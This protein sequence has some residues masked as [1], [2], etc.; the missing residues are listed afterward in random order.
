MFKDAKNLPN[1]CPLIKETCIGANCS[2]SKS[3]EG[4][5]PQTGDKVNERVCGVGFAPELAMEGN[6]LT[7]SAV[8]T[9][10]T[11]RNSA[12]SQNETIIQLLTT[13]IHT[14]ANAE[15]VVVVNN[16]DKQLKTIT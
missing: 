14:V 4:L 16:Q 11:A 12:V 15:P 6:A 9:A 1:Y 13:L 8:A 2:F 10:E 3:I 7:N 5:H